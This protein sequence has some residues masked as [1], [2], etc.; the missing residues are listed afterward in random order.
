[1]E[2][3]I[4]GSTCQKVNHYKVQDHLLTLTSHH[5][6]DLSFFCSFWPTNFHNKENQISHSKIVTQNKKL[7]S[8]LCSSSSSSS[9]LFQRIPFTDSWN[10]SFPIF[11]PSLTLTFNSLFYFLPPPFYFSWPFSITLFSFPSL[12]SSSFSFSLHSTPAL[13]I[14][15]QFTSKS[16]FHFFFF[17]L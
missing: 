5:D 2:E 7:S 8:S 10:L 11:I 4:N 16:S 6:S 3:G 15:I 13:V 9:T 12:S 14:P 1:M 17:P